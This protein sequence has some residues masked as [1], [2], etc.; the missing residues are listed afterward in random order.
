MTATSHLRTIVLD[1]D[2]TITEVDLLDD[3]GRR[4]GDPAVYQE[5]EDGIHAGT[6]TLQECITREYAPVTM[7]LEDAVNW[8]LANIRVRPGLLEL[9]S[10]ARARAWDV[11]V[12]SSGFREIIE[13]V[14]DHYGI[15][16]VE[17]VANR[18]DA[19][20][21]GWRVVWRDETVC[22]VCGEP[23][24]R[25][26]LPEG[27]IVYVGDGIS[28]R[29]AALAS[30]RVFATRGLARYLDERGVRYEPFDDFNDIVRALTD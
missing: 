3:M 21:D 24:K 8:V 29:C 23:C 26:G 2:G 9:V 28:D 30:Q 14:L 20:P 15:E 27:E 1:F 7:P 13:P 25:S 17:V 10:L 11:R 22:E 12:L 16:G 6:I 4:F 19:R 18:V 5:A